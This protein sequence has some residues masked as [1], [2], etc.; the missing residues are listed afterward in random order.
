MVQGTE[1]F[2]DMS[3]A[4]T[5]YE[6]PT[7][8]RSKPTRFRGRRMRAINPARTNDQPVIPIRTAHRSRWDVLSVVAVEIAANVPARRAAGATRTKSRLSVIRGAA[9]GSLPRA[10]PSG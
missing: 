1:S 3:P 6:S 7:A 8:I 2:E 9:P 5:K 4:E 10:L